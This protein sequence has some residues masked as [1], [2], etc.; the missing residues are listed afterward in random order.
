MRGWAPNFAAF[1]RD[2]WVTSRVA[3]NDAQQCPTWPV[4]RTL[5]TCEFAGQ[6]PSV[7]SMQSCGVRR[8][9]AAVSSAVWQRGLP[10]SA[11]NWHAGVV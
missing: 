6:I 4:A 7:G 8:L 10:R 1:Y 9:A 5:T 2:A 11:R 3:R